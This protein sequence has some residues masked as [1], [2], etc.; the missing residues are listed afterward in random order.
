MGCV[1]CVHKKISLLGN[2]MFEVN[3]SHRQ[4]K[5]MMIFNIGP[6]F[7]FQR[8]KNQNHINEG[9]YEYDGKALKLKWNKWEHETLNRKGDSDE[10]MSDVNNFII[11]FGRNLE[12][13]KLTARAQ[14]E[15]DE[16]ESE[17]RMA[18]MEE[19]KMI[20]EKAQIEAEEAAATDR[21]SFEKAAEERVNIE[22]ARAKKEDMKKASE[23][24]SAKRAAEKAA[25]KAATELAAAEKVAEKKA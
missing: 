18:M 1:G 2:K 16:L 22:M 21:E 13:L 15:K 4:W 23:E 11:K 20:E 24:K 12:N 19:Q 25:E 8:K 10:F 9:L 3:A 6:K 17:K 7:G 5:D 14:D